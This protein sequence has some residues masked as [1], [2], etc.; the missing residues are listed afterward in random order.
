MNRVII[1]LAGLLVMF[2]GL[3]VFNS[4]DDEPVQQVN[5]QQQ[6]TATDAA[7]VTEAERD[8]YVN[9]IKTIN[10]R[11]VAL[12]Q[13]IKDMQEKIDEQNKTSLSR[14]D[15]ESIAQRSS[16]QRA[17]DFKSIMDDKFNEF[18]SVL[19][20]VKNKKSNST[21]LMPQG[22][23]IDQI[24]GQM[25]SQE[26]NQG[27]RNS[28]SAFG[29]PGQGNRYVTITPLA[30]VSTIQS[31][32]GMTDIKMTPDGQPM[33]VNNEDEGVNAS[34]G[35]RSSNKKKRKAPV[36]M[37]TIPQNAT[38][39]NNASMT[40]LLGIV[41][42]NGQIL[43]PV[44]FK[45]ITGSENIATNGL[46]L[47]PGIKNIIWSGI[48]LGNREMSCTYGQLNSVTFTFEDGRVTT[49]NSQT[50][51]GQDRLGGRM[52]GY[53]TTKSGNPCIS[54]ELISNASQYLE[55]RM[56]ASG[57]ASAGQ[58]F[59]NTQKDVNT[60]ANGTVIESFNGNTADY[61]LGN[62]LSGSLEELVQ[63][64]R[65]RQAQAIDI[66][67]VPNGQE[68]V[69]HVEKEIKIDY[70]PNGRMIDHANQIPNNLVS[71]AGALD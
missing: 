24:V 41:P 21:Q 29:L 5:K 23:G 38:L 10:A 47:P 9:T 19:E 35:K 48:A 15:V 49:I 59:S 61:I 22:L 3:M 17:R 53:I 68:F 7:E 65:N 67:Y 58:A 12:E 30:T 13:Q 33:T 27:T 45:I 6:K 25:N 52:L 44:R 31:R 50:D 1:L 40:A 62:T 16:E 2:I 57:F 20:E 36:P 42:V 4:G 54:G 43:D 18:T 39:F 46:Y 64:L 34:R 26:D 56:W 51:A 14:Q 70:D 69:V 37:Y 63:Y 66:V 71:A 32:N 11:A 60:T 8:D 28:M 55:D